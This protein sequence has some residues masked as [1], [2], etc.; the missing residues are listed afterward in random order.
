MKTSYFN[1]PVIT[2]PAIA[3]SVQ[4]AAFAA[5]DVVFDWVSFEIPRGTAKLLGATIVMVGKNVTTG[6]PQPAGIDLIFAKDTVVSATPTTLGVGGADPTSP[7]RNDIIGVMPSGTA[8]LVGGRTTYQGTVSSC[9]LVLEPLTTTGSN[10]GV[11]KYWVAGIAGGAI[12]FESE[13][14]ADGTAGT[15]QKN[16]DI[17]DVAGSLIFQV[18]DVVHDE[19][20]R[21]IGTVHTITDDT[22]ILMVANLANALVNDKKVYPLNPVKSIVLHFSK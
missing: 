10:V 5:G 3:A 18:G 12:T 9:E 8:D 2:P 20:D 15:G 13:C 22:N 11:D 17:A 6:T 14:T 1:S 16:M 4:H 21:L 7:L 19:D